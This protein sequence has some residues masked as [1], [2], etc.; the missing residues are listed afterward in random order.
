MRG[1]DACLITSGQLEYKSKASSGTYLGNASIVQVS[2][3]GSLAYV[4]ARG[5]S[6]LSIYDISA[7]PAAPT[8]VGS[9]YHSGMYD[10]EGLEVYG[11]YAFIVARGSPKAMYVFDISNPASPSFVTTVASSPANQMNNIWG[12]DLSEDGQYA[13]TVSWNSGSSSNRC[14]FH[15]IDISD[16]PNSNISATINFTTASG[17]SWR[18]CSKV[19]V[20]GD[21]AYLSFTDGG[22]ATFDISNP[23][24]PVYLDSASG[25]VTQTEAMAISEDGKYAFQV[26]WQN[27]GNFITFDIND[28]SNISFVNHLQSSLIDVAWAVTV[29]GNYAFVGADAMPALVAI[30]ISNPEAPVVSGHVSDSANMNEPQYAAFYGQYAYVPGFASNSLAVVDIGCDITGGGGSAPTAGLISHW[31]LDESSGTTAFATVG[32]LDATLHNGPQWQTAGGVVGGALQFT[33]GSNQHAITTDSS[34]FDADPG[35]VVSVSFWFKRNAMQGDPWEY[36]LFK[37]AHCTGWTFDIDN[38]ALWFVLSTSNN[39][40]TSP[41]HYH[42]IANDVRYDDGEWHHAVGIIDRPAGQIRL[43]VDGN[44]KATTSSINSAAGNPGYDFPFRFGADWENNRNYKGMLDD[45]R[46]Y[47]RALTLQEIGTLYSYRGAPMGCCQAL[48]SCSSPAA[49]NFFAGE[50]VLAY[51]DGDEWRPMAGESCG[52]H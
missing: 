23:L 49:M 46:I 21:I 16:P 51:C 24:S 11:N 48:G 33:G 35:D 52:A 34:I 40:C 5:S 17:S 13:Y 42:A 29:K 30:D 14:Y 38:G 25:P 44:L 50:R 6:R 10:G 4:L 37:E 26:S 19:K 22:M 8:L 27:G 9:V 32:G 45:V 28:P 18:Y 2:P 7:S 12:I 47:D 1:G 43:Y 15:V 41:A 3:D 31:K 20:R 36:L 39:H